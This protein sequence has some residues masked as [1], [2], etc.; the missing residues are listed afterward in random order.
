MASALTDR[1]SAAVNGAGTNASKVYKSVSGGT[2]TNVAGYVGIFIDKLVVDGS[3][4]L[5]VVANKSGIYR[6]NGSWAAINN[7]LNSVWAITAGATST[8]LYATTHLGLH[9][10]DANTNAWVLHHNGL[11]T[12]SVNG[13]TF[14]PNGEL[15]AATL[16]GVYRSADG[17]AT[18]SNDALAD[19]TIAAVSYDAFFNQYYSGTHCEEI[20][21]H[22][23]WN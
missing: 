15:L 5:H 17:G 6:Y 12:G 21:T 11:N 1:L 20:V 18:W 9:R 2:W 10:W 23:F 8:G 14:G 4:V 16:D 3:G 19:K 7:G 13:I 22:L